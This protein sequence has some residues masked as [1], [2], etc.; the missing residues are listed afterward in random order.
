VTHPPP[1]GSPEDEN[2]ARS[3]VK[4]GTRAQTATPGPKADAAACDVTA[5][6]PQRGQA[7]WFIAPAQLNHRRYE[8]LRAL[9]TE[10][11]A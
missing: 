8:V 4:P 7:E 9:F 1:S 6:W 11:L 2:L 5:G 3:S 10:G